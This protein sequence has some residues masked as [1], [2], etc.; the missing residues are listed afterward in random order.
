MSTTKERAN[1]AISALTAVLAEDEARLWPVD[2]TA[3]QS[4]LD[5]LR[6]LAR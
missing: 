3:I 6:D 2:R 5:V 4:A 1:R